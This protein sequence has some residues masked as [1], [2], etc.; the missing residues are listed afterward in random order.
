MAAHRFQIAALSDCRFLVWKL[1]FGFLRHYFEEQ[2]LRHIISTAPAK[3]H[4]FLIPKY[5]LGCKRII[6]DPVRCLV[7]AI[8][9][10]R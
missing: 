6:L 4:D 5:P 9:E 1:E 7:I 3:Y 2:S 10:T 8:A